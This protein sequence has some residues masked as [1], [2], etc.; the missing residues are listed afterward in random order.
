MM[1]L[2]RTDAGR[3]LGA[4]LERYRRDDVIVLGLPRGGVVVAGE[5]ARALH[6]PLD[7]LVARKLGVPRYPER[8]M[9]A[10]AGD[11][12][13]VNDSVVN[14]MRVP[15]SEVQRVI[16]EERREL[17]R[18]EGLFRRG[19][20]PLDLKEK[21]VILVDDGIATGAT[22]AV[23][24]RALRASR[25]AR[26]V[27]ATPVS[28]REAVRDLQWEADEVVALDVPASFGS[29]GSYYGDFEQTTDAEVID[30]LDRAPRPAAREPAGAPR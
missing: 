20:A 7:V 16:A 6:A 23:A 19:R 12:I 15:E 26:I 9:G 4:A 11:Q 28:S 21:T 13:A 30:L 10:I 1:F 27:V 8:A 17:A 2:D 18:R 14:L 22:A 25:P 3:R 24:V 29:V 5:V